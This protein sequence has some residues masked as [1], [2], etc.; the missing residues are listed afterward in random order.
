MSEIIWLIL[1]ILVGW[2]LLGLGIGLLIGRALR[3]LGAAYDKS[4]VADDLH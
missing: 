3:A 2:T 1:K 4:D